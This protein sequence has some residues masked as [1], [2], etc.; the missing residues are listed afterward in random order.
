MLRCTGSSS[1]Q[2]RSQQAT[3]MSPLQ[4]P[5]REEVC[6][7]LTAPGL[8]QLLQCCW[9]QPVGFLYMRQLC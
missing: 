7:R 2:Q 9:V 3:C 6:G 1:E 4:T 5:Q 8:M